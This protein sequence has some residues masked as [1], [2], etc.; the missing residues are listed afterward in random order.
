[1]LYMLLFLAFPVATVAGKKIFSHI[2]ENV[3]DCAPLEKAGLDAMFY[4]GQDSCYGFG[5]FPGLFSKEA[6][7]PRWKCKF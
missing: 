6:V 7:P 3:A 2:P 5:Y 4:S 1:M